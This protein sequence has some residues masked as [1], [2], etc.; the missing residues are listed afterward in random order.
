MTTFE[1]AAERIDARWESI[2]PIS[3]IPAA[4][5]QP[6]AGL[7]QVAESARIYREREPS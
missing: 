2:K 7:T 6:S 3:D 1:Q 4:A 5:G